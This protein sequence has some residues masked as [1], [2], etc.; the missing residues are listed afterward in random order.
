MSVVQSFIDSGSLLAIRG[1][2]IVI[3][4][5]ILGVVLALYAVYWFIFKAGK[6]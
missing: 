2:A 3:G 5:L 1:G 4:G 6:D